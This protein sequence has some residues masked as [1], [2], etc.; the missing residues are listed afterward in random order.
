MLYGTRFS[1][2]GT[3]ELPVLS[4]GLLANLVQL[5]GTSPLRCRESM[6]SLEQQ[7]PTLGLVHRAE[8]C[9]TLRVVDLVLIGIN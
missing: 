9:L 6:L 3:C 4:G 8:G 1:R 7:L 2:D 5:L